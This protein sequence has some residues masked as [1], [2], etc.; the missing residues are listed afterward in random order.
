MSQNIGKSAES[1]LSLIISIG[2]EARKFSYINADSL[3]TPG[4]GDYKL[5][6]EFASKPGWTIGSKP[7]IKFANTPGPN[8]YYPKAAT[9]LTWDSSPTTFPKSDRSL[10]PPEIRKS[11]SISTT[12]LVE[13]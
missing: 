5:P 7:S 9:I 10:L 4:V 2:G 3:K 1:V 13:I 8:A 6:S 11:R 12:R